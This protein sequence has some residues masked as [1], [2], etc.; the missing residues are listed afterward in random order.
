[1]TTEEKDILIC[2]SI[3]LVGIVMGL[4]MIVGNL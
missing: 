1:M 3:I 2:V 4:V